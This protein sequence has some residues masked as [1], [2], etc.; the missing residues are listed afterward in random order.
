M[1]PLPGV[2]DDGYLTFPLLDARAV[3]ELRA[4]FD[5][6]DM[7]RTHGFHATSAHGDRAT[8]VEVDGFLKRALGRALAE[9]LPG[10]E[11]FL[12]AFISKGADAGVKVDYHQDWTYTDERSHRSILL[13]I[14]L[15]DTSDENGGLRVLPG[16]HRWTDGLRPS[17]AANPLND[18]EGPL[19]AGATA[20][21]VPAGHAFT[22]DPGLVHGSGPN[23]TGEQRVVAAIALAPAGAPLVHF[24]V[25]AD[26]GLTGW[27]IDA[28][29]YTVAPF[30]SR[31]EGCAP[32]VPWTRAVE[33]ADFLPHV[34]P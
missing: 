28:S 34:A 22:Y 20:V 26:G 17:G 11:P 7:P 19:D 9:R 14:P 31:P 5:A 27:A 33:T 15:V 30:G 10:H 1:N 24:H 3:S 12:A 4:A 29:H 18:L 23:P 13:W 6:L 2:T 25:D 21:P 32:V 16:S 8:A